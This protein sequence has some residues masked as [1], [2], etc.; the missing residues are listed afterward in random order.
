MKKLFLL[1]IAVL[2]MTAVYGQTTFEKTYGKINDDY[3]FSV[4]KTFDGGYIIAAPFNKLWTIIKTDSQGDTIWQRTYPFL[5]VHSYQFTNSII[6]TSDSNYVLAGGLVDS[7]GFILKVNSKGDT[8]WFKK[9]GKAFYPIVYRRVVEDK[10]GNLIVVGSFEILNASVC[11]SSLAQKFNKNGQMILWGNIPGCPASVGCRF[12]EICIDKFDSGYLMSGDTPSGGPPF[13]RLVKIDTSGNV[14]WD[15][16][17]GTMSGTITSVLSVADSGYICSGTNSGYD[18]VLVLKINKSG[19]IQTIKKYKGCSESTSIAN[20]NG[21]YLISGSKYISGNQD[22]F[23]LKIDSNY[24]LLWSKTYGGSQNEY[25]DMMKSTSD[26]GCV[27]VGSTKSYG[28]GG[29]DVYFIKTDQNGLVLAQNEITLSKEFLSVFPNPFSAQTVLRADDFLY[30]ATLIIYNSIGQ[31]VKQIKNISGQT[32]TLCRDN[33]PS[34]LY[35]LRLTERDKI[36]AADKVV[37]TDE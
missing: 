26:G 16:G 9:S 13:P 15:K 7:N 27:I 20:S 37:I 34:G 31:M 12:Q 35:F 11:C 1:W 33:L 6:Q 24:T 17:Y 29:Y 25:F 36:I 32:I 14:V 19:N 10:Q 5:N 4:A 3:G 28:A 8:V 18:S 30:K 21:G 2:G 22:L 23:L